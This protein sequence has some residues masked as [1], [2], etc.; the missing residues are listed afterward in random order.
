VKK[1]ELIKTAYDRD[2]NL[3]EEEWMATIDPLPESPEEMMKVAAWL[4]KVHEMDQ[5]E[6]LLEMLVEAYE[7]QKPGAPSADIALQVLGWFP[8]NNEFRKAYARQLAS[9]HSAN[10]AITGIIEKSK[11]TGDSELTAALREI[12]CRLNIKTGKYAI[13]RMRR[14]PVRIESYDPVSDMLVLSNGDQVFDTDL[15]T[16]TDQYDSL[17]DVDFRAQRLFE[18]QKLAEMA[19]SDPCKLIKNYLLVCGKESTFRSFKDI[20][21]DSI[22]DPADWKE[23][24]KETKTQLVNDPYIQL[25]TGSQ[26]SLTLRETPR[27]FSEELKLDFDH[28]GKPYKRPAALIHYLN[29]I[30]QGIPAD[31]AV[32]THFTE[33][34]SAGLPDGDAYALASWLALSYAAKK[35]ICEQ[36]VYSAEWLQKDDAFKK[37]IQWCG[38][39]PL[40]ISVCVE[41]FSDNEPEWAVYYS[42]ALPK[43][44]FTFVE[45]VIPLL[46]QTEKPEL[47]LPLQ[48]A[49][50]QPHVDTGEAFAWTWRQLAKGQPLP[51]QY[52]SE[53][54]ESTMVLFDLISQSCSA[55]EDENLNMGE[56]ISVLRQTVSCNH[57]LLIKSVFS[58]VAEQHAAELYQAV[59]VNPGISTL[60]RSQ[61]VQLLANMGG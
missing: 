3:L 42:N 49:M 18:K 47:F 31:P 43:M 12:N 14:M 22:I 1:Q 46:L 34:L 33:Q 4:I 38:W 9:V 41:F 6:I 44:P 54:F 13:H 24:W 27:N 19:V 8:N 20:F 36:P 59:T 16:L 40:L 45:R 58:S 52:D 5:A 21:R 57:Y 29:E 25:G 50:V 28:A 48:N 11:L 35:G 10:P 61:L 30:D 51:F 7:E 53:L 32:L 15:N 60:M 23:W 55:H 39:E 2:F 56:I 37:F 17:P 26:P